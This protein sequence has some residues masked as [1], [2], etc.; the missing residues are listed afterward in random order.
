MNG[1]LTQWLKSKFSKSNSDLFS[2]FM[3]R[4]LRSLPQE[5]FAGLHDSIHMDVPQ[6]V[7]RLTGFDYLSIR[8][9]FAHSP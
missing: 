7:L 8:T 1:E 3:E 6:F 4:V 9:F 5:G 2:A